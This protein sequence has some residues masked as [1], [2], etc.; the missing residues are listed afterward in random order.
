MPSTIEQTQSMQ[1]RLRTVRHLIDELH[2]MD[3]LLNQH[4]GLADE[5]EIVAPGPSVKTATIILLQE[6]QM[7][8]KENPTEFCRFFRTRDYVAKV[9]ANTKKLHRLTKLSVLPFH[10]HCSEEYMREGLSQH[11]WLPSSINQQQFRF[12]LM[13]WAFAQQLASSDLLSCTA[14][15]GLPLSVANVLAVCHTQQV[16]AFC[17]SCEQTFR[18]NLDTKYLVEKLDDDTENMLFPPP[19]PRTAKI[20]KFSGVL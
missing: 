5:D 8:A 6:A 16:L 9:F 19:L 18:F 4:Y 14:V 17:S 20:R 1:T 12:S 13:Y 15:T 10:P 11:K 7:L 2:A 3:A